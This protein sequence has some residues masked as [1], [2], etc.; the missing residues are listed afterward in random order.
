MSIS[1]ADTVTNSIDISGPWEDKGLYDINLV[2]TSKAPSRENIIQADEENEYLP[3]R[4]QTTPDYPLS[5]PGC[6]PCSPRSDYYR[7]GAG[8]HHQ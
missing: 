6:L 4:T 3:N 8:R 5:L 1:A 2:D 7:P